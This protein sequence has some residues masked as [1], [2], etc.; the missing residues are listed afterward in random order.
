MN[1]GSTSN[2]ASYYV[3]NAGDV[4]TQSSGAGE[5][6]PPPSQA[7]AENDYT[8]KVTISAEAMARSS[9]GGEVQPPPK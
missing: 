4:G 1:I 2:Q 3:S 7:S 6:Q 8:D 9:G 5:V